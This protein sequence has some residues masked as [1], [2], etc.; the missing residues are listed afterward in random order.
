LE[1]LKEAV[2]KVARVAVLYDP[3]AP[4]ILLEVK[5][6]LPLAARALGLTLQ[7][8]DVRAAPDFERAFAAMGKQRPDGLSVAAGRLISN[9]QKK[10]VGFALKSRLPSVYTTREAVDAGGLLYYGIDLAD[11]SR[12]IAYYVDKILKGA[13]PADLPVQQPT[14]FELVINQQT[15]K[16]IG[17]TIAQSMLYRADKVIKDAPG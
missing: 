5:D 6:I 2:P 12:R 17:V 16:Q 7:P 8:W 13:K 11:S 10:I 15:A 14:K 9:S 4:G 1:L 3:A